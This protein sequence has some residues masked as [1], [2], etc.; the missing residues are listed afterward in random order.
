VTTETFEIILVLN[1][2]SWNVWVSFHCTSIE[3]STKL[4]T[5][6]WQVTHWREIPT[7]TCMSMRD[8][9]W[10]QL[11]LVVRWSYSHEL[12]SLIHILISSTPV[13]TSIAADEEWAFAP[14]IL[15]KHCTC[16]LSSLSRSLALADAHTGA[17]YSKWGRTKDLYSCIPSYTD[18]ASR[19]SNKLQILAADLLAT[20]TA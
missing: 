4:F 5:H 16:T 3:R 15:L 20:A 11:G 10:R 19:P 14:V 1:S 13:I 8:R 12:R 17:A 9:R 18:I 6:N 7:F 2:T